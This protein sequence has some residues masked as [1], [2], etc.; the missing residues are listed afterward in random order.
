MDASIAR[1]GCRF[2]WFCEEE[3]SVLPPKAS[4]AFA[5]FIINSVPMMPRSRLK[6]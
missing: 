5:S 2:E 1:L 3:S 6:L 4:Q